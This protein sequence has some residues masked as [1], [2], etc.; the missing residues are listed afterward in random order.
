MSGN[1]CDSRDHETKVHRLSLSNNCSPERKNKV[2]K[3]RK[4]REEN[5]GDLY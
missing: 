5:E 4:K 1:I 3:K 2:R